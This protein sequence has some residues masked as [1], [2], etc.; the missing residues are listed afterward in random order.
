MTTRM[1]FHANAVFVHRERHSDSPFTS[2]VLRFPQDY[3][4]HFLPTRA[5]T[6]ENSLARMNCNWYIF[7]LRRLSNFDSV[8]ERLPMLMP[9]SLSGRR[10]SQPI[11]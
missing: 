11:S 2:R 10:V 1:L 6:W 4:A 9:M 7:I 8:R 5:N 3:L